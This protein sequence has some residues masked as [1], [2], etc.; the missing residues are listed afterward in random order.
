MAF[1][2]ANSIVSTTLKKCLDVQFSIHVASGEFDETVS[3]V[4]RFRN[5]SRASPGGSALRRMDGG[6][7]VAINTWFSSRIDHYR[8]AP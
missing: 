3:D 7:K 4:F 5:G 8:P 1:T 6:F 2:E